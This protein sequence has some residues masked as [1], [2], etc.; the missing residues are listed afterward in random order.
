MGKEYLV[1]KYEEAP[2]TFILTQNLCDGST[3]STMMRLK[4]WR[5]HRT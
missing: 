1:F 4:R 3:N 2:G 5:I